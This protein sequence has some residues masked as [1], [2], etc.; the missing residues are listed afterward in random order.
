MTYTNI[1]L[2]KTDSG[3]FIVDDGAPL[4]PMH[5]YEALEMANWLAHLALKRGE[6]VKVVYKTDDGSELILRCEEVA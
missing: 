6:S 5:K 1:E 2:R 4:N 3:L